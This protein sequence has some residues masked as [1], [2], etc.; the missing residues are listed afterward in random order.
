M[1]C[2]FIP[3]C[4]IACWV[5][6]AAV[7]GASLTRFLFNDVAGF[8]FG[9]FDADFVGSSCFTFGVC[10]ASKESSITSC[11]NYHICAT[12]FTFSAF[13]GFESDWLNGA[14]F[15]AFEFHGIFAIGVSRAGEEVAIF[16]P[17]DN[18]GFVTFIAFEVGF[19]FFEFD[20]A[21]FNAGDFEFFFEGGVEILE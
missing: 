15:E 21:D 12:F 5:G 14:I 8:T 16:S 10:G 17:S 2:W 6:V 1:C 3:G 18:E 7:E 4:E 19:F 11:F 9:A 13:F 20:V